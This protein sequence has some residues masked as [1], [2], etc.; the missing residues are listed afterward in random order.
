[1]FVFGAFWC[2]CIYE[3]AYGLIS[4]HSTKFGA[5]KAIRKILYDIWTEHRKSQLNGAVKKNEY[6]YEN[7]ENYDNPIG[8]IHTDWEIRKIEINNY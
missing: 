6:G 4:L 5:Y 7:Y 8:L 3:S 2:D 1:M